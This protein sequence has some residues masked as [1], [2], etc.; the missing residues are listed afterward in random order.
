MRIACVMF[1]TLIC[2]AVVSIALRNFE[3]LLI[4][5][6]LSEFCLEKLCHPHELH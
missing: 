2:T 4:K 6:S 5:K 1:L 3:E